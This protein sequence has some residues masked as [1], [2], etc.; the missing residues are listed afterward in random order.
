MR[1]TKTGAEVR[2]GA[3][4]DGGKPQ[5]EGDGKNRICH[6]RHSEISSSVSKAPQDRKG[7]RRLR[8]RF[9]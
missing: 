6:V 7:D 4:G 1:R 3:E 8:M 9:F 5:S 2:G